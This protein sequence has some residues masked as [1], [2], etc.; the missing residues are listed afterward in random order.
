MG[1][2][3]ASPISLS[4]A[5]V[6]GWSTLRSCCGRVLSFACRPQL[7]HHAAHQL[8]RFV[9]RLHHDLQIHGGQSRLPI[10]LAVHSMLS[11]HRQRVG[12]GIQCHCQPSARASH[13]HFV[14]FKFPAFSAK[15][16][17]DFRQ[18]ISFLWLLRPSRRMKHVLHH[19]EDAFHLFQRHHLQRLP[20]ASCLQQREQ[21]YC[22]AQSTNCRAIHCCNPSF[23]EC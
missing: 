8:F 5:N 7:L 15:N 22:H 21:T 14:E 23:V 20:C 4:R 9:Q 2:A 19:V 6:V 11:H 18:S 16:T 10:A 13:L 12:Q 1:E 17:L 3:S